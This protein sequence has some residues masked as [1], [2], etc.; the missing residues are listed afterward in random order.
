MIIDLRECRDC[1]KEG[2]VRYLGIPSVELDTPMGDALIRDMS[3]EYM[4]HLNLNL[5]THEAID[6]GKLSSSFATQL[7]E[8]QF[9]DAYVTMKEWSDALIRLDGYS[10]DV[11]PPHVVAE[12]CYRFEEFLEETFESIEDLFGHVSKNLSGTVCQIISPENEKAGT[13]FLKMVPIISDSAVVR[14]HCESAAVFKKLVTE[15]IMSD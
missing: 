3:R 15:I 11:D 5:F 8:H 9:V 10:D 13:Y 12:L 2:L 6:Q 7:H 4:R 1:I 14:R